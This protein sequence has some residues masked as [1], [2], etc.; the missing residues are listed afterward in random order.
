MPKVWIA[1]MT[2]GEYSD[3]TVYFVGVFDSRDEAEAA[4]DERYT[5]RRR[6]EGWRR[7]TPMFDWKRDDSESTRDADERV[8]NNGSPARA[9][10]TC[11]ERGVRLEFYL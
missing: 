5:E 4:V 6:A 10:V 7:I 9:A 8:R 3:T 2:E 1:T 11:V